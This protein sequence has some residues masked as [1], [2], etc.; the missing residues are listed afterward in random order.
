MRHATWSRA[1]RAMLWAGDS[2]RR[3]VG[4]GDASRNRASTGRIIELQRQTVRA[5]ADGARRRPEARRAEYATILPQLAE[6]GLVYEQAM[7]VARHGARARTRRRRSSR[8]VD[9]ARAILARLGARPL[10][11]RL[12]ELLRQPA[13]EG[14]AAE[15]GARVAETT[16]PKAV[17]GGP[18]AHRQR[19]ESGRERTRRR[20]ARDRSASTSQWD[21]RNA[22]V[23]RRR[24]TR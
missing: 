10:A 14:S 20:H 18:E 24:R 23:N 6:M 19:P 9:E 16:T 11:T 12:E 8:A 13:R 4:A 17:R 3:A 5:A 15:A 2:R 1:A 21:A 7:V 22:Q